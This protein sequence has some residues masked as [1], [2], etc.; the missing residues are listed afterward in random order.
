[1]DAIINF[2]QTCKLYLLPCLGYSFGLIALVIYAIRSQDWKQEIVA[3]GAAIWLFTR[4]W[5]LSAGL[6]SQADY[7]DMPE[8]RAMLSILLIG[9]CAIVYANMHNVLRKA[10]PGVTGLFP[11]AKHELKRALYRGQVEQVVDKLYDA[12]YAAY[13]VET[14]ELLSAMRYNLQEKAALV[15]LDPARRYDQYNEQNYLRSQL[16]EMLH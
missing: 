9:F 16:E 12:A 13:D 2:G 10:L 11:E 4:I 1:M 7:H 15:E 8:N 14:M 5:H 6:I 3:Y